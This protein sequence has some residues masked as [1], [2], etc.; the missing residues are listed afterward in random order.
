MNDLITRIQTFKAENR[1]YL[2]AIDL[3][4]LEV[5][6]ELVQRVENLERKK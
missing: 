3:T 1:K 4:M 6:M 2:S 5:I